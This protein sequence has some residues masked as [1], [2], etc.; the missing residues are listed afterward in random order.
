MTRRLEAQALQAAEKR[1]YFAIPRE[2][3]NLSLI[4]TQEK[5]DSSARG[6]PRN[7]KYLSF[8]AAC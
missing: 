6:A 4:E 7:D 3:R 5:R 2:A 8:S 1:I